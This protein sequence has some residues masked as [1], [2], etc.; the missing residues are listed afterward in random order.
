M[1]YTRERRKKYSIFNAQ[2]FSQQELPLVFG[3]RNMELGTGRQA[4][5]ATSEVNY[6]T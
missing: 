2:V 3:I 4:G 5:W 1:G 6:N